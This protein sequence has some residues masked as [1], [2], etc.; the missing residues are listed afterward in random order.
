MYC[1]RAKRE[2]HAGFTPNF[3]AMNTCKINARLALATHFVSAVARAP[4][5]CTFHIHLNPIAFNTCAPPRPN[6]F[7]LR[8]YVRGRVEG[9]TKLAKQRPGRVSPVPGLPSPITINHLCFQE[10]TNS[11]KTT[12]NMSRI[13]I[14]LQTPTSGKEADLLPLQSITNSRP[15]RGRG[16]YSDL[17][18]KSMEVE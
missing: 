7:G 9:D 12:K 16:R 4:R 3:L 10:I 13:F 1:A 15:K 6:A 11:R 17:E 5:I 14:R 8:G 18:A 2:L